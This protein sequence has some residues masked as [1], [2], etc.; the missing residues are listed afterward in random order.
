MYLTKTTQNTFVKDQTPNIFLKPWAD[1]L[2]Q[3]KKS[4]RKIL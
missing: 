1:L 2:C 3:R 4:G